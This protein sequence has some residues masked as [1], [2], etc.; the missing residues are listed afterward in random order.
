MRADNAKFRQYQIKAKEI[1]L[2][3]D[4]FQKELEREKIA[5]R[6][7]YHQHLEVI[8]AKFLHLTLKM[9]SKVNSKVT[10]GKPILDFL[11]VFYSY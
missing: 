4:H 3:R 2:D 5:Y 6:K 10:N 9:R 1:K 7:L 8:C 11:Y